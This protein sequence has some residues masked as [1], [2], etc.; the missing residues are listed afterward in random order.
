MKKVVIILFLL[1][2]HTGLAK[3][4]EQ[5]SLFHDA[6]IYT[7]VQW[8]AGEPAV[9]TP[10]FWVYIGDYY[11]EARY[12]YENLETASLYFGHSFSFGKNASI[13]LTPLLGGVVGAT[14]GIS[15]GFNFNLEY[16]SFVTSTQ[17]QYTFDLKDFPGSFFWD[18]TN[19]SFNFSDHFGMG[20]GMQ[21][22]IPQSGEKNISAGPMIVLGYKRL[23]LEM[24]VYNFWERQ[25]TYAVG[26]VYDFMQSSDDK[27]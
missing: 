19:F 5:D 10:Q 22:F 9:V 23:S 14:N 7:T 25:P 11:L 26:L 4:Q 12:N 21:L 17:C 3:A 2:L 13:E 15:P 1:L 6:G 24:Y 16:K 18:W 27:N 20:G 8:S